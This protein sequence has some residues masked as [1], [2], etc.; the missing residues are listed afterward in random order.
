MVDQQDVEV[1]LDEE[2][3]VLFPGFEEALLG[4]TKGEAVEFD[5]AVPE[6]IT[7]RSSPARQAHFVVTIKETKEEVLPELDEEF[8][9]AVGEGFESVDAL[10]ERIR[11]DIKKARGGAARQPL[12]RRDP[13][14][15]SSSARRSSSRR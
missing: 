4:A 7:A 12:P 10:R 8:P 6:T 3:D 14:R 9:K 5:L 13:R 2:R 1:Q 15:S 11:E